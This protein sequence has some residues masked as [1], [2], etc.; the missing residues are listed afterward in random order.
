MQGDE[1]YG[2]HK[3]RTGQYEEKQESSRGAPFP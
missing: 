1:G 3:A 2:K